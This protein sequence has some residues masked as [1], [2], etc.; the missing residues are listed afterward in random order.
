MTVW[1]GLAVGWTIFLMIAAGVWL[2]FV[3][4]VRAQALTA[5]AERKARA[6]ELQAESIRAGGV[7]GEGRGAGLTEASEAFREEVARKRGEFG[8][9]TGV[10]PR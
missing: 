5:M 8:R 3:M 10:M 7:W 2:R 4:Q 1:A 9:R 6:M